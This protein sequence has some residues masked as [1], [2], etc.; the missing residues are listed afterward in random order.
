[1]K[2]MMILSL[3][4]TLSVTCFAAPS[5]FGPTGMIVVPS[6]DSLGGGEFDLA[7]HHFS[8]TNILSFS[9]GVADGFEVGLSAWNRGDS[10]TTNGFLKYTIVPERSSQIG[11]AVGGRA[12][13]NHNSFFVVG[14]KYLQEIGFRG[15]LGLDT[16]GDGTFFM[17]LSKALPSQKAFPKPIV[18]AE[19]Y[20]GDLN[21]GLRMLVT[22]EVNLDLSL[23]DLNTLQIG[24]SFHSSF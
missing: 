7:L 3:L 24:L 13:S 14:S 9:M 16:R 5:M 21:L 11:L 17:G 23:L 12:S 18:M 10:T 19:F 22:R 8:E 4:L 20:G 1:M 2:K 15:H 6:A